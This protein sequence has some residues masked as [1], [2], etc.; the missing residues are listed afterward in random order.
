MPNLRISLSRI[1]SVT[2]ISEIHTQWTFTRYWEIQEMSEMKILD[3]H[4][5]NQRWVQK[6]LNLVKHLLKQYLNVCLCSASCEG[7]SQSFYTQLYSVHCL[8]FFLKVTTWWFIDTWVLNHKKKW[9]ASSYRSFQRILFQRSF[10]SAY[11]VGKFMFKS[12]LT[13]R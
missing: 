4:W 1:E 10:L 6:T 12:V 5:T 8:N 9:I 2:K 3:K 7:M 11:K 13:F